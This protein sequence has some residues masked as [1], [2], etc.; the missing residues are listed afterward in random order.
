MKQGPK[1]DSHAQ[2]TLRL[3]LLEEDM[4]APSAGHAAANI[5]NLSTR[6]AQQMGEQRG[7][8]EVQ[9]D[10]RA[11]ASLAAKRFSHA[12]P[13]Q[14]LSA[15]PP[16]KFD[17]CSP[18][19]E[20]PLDHEQ[21][22]QVRIIEAHH[23]P[24]THRYGRQAAPFAS[25]AF[26]PSPSEKLQ[27]VRTDSVPGTLAPR[28]GQTFIFGYDAALESKATVYFNLE[29]RGASIV[30]ETMGQSCQIPL[31]LIAQRPSRALEGW[32]SL[33]THNVDHSRVIRA[34]ESLAHEPHITQLRVNLQ[35]LPPNFRPG[36]PE[37]I[38]SSGGHT[39]HVLSSGGHTPYLVS[40]AAALS[41]PALPSASMPA[42]RLETAHEPVT[43]GLV[44]GAVAA[45]D[46]GITWM[47]SV[48]QV[49]LR[50]ER[51]RVQR[52]RVGVRRERKAGKEA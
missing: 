50:R 11:S 36:A 14:S 19:A 7:E 27:A 45:G 38:S 15:A 26:K 18:A 9:L 5:S 34:T 51:A 4:D 21:R 49:R 25:I 23:E 28:Y 1:P 31:S 33:S 2:L 6:H 20:G 44:R 48:R 8:S 32:L 17:M 22:V 35:L 43:G 39:P 3:L 13:R 24:A 30:D 29:D 16:L 41:P 10:A 47:D 52:E 46:V 12:S 42:E 40:Q 37:A